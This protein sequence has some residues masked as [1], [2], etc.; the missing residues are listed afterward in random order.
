MHPRQMQEWSTNEPPTILMGIHSET[1]N[2]VR[3]ILHIVKLEQ[4]TQPRG[5]LENQIR[6]AHDPFHGVDKVSQS[7]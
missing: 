4:K 1:F 6:L 5:N 2:I 7:F 3:K